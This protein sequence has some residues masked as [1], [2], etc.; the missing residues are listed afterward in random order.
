[1]K[2]TGVI[3]IALALLI[4]LP[5]VVIA[6][7]GIPAVPSAG[8]ITSSRVIVSEGTVM[9][10]SSLGWSI[11]YGDDDDG[12]ASRNDDGSSMLHRNQTQYSTTYDANIIA[13]AG[14]TNIVKT[15]TISTGNKLITQSN[16]KA[17]TTVNFMATGDGGNIQGTENIMMDGTS[18]YTTTPGS[19]IVTCPFGGS[20][21]GYSFP[22]YCNIVQA[23]SKYDMVIGSV[24]TTANDRFVDTDATGPVVLNYAINVKP[25]TII[26]SGT[27][28]ALGSASAYI[29][30]HIQ[31]GRTS[32]MTDQYEDVT[33]AESSSAAG[34][35]NSFSKTI[36]YQS[37]K[38]LL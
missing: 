13:L 26:G 3:L 35:I 29:K 34:I 12:L 8:G 24:V 17:D 1:M 31:E 4:A 33:Y 15:L 36:A 11:S 30:A 19:R 32:I 38:R 23:G 16:I 20:S 7:Q 27:S 2:K 14:K 9:E 37:G 5:G 21:G 28:P 18:T 10:S 22:A 25:Y 6:D